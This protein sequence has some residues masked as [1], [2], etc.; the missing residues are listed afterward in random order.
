MTPCHVLDS[1]TGCLSPRLVYTKGLLKMK[2]LILRI[3]QELLHNWDTL[4]YYETQSGRVI[5]AQYLHAKQRQRLLAQDGGFSWPRI[6]WS[7][8]FLLQT[9]LTSPC[10]L[11]CLA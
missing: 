1:T 9:L 11:S 2:K 8:P 7:C 5:E 3:S 6:T 10:S 4:G